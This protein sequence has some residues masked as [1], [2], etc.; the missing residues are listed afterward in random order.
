MC[1]LVDLLVQKRNNRSYKPA[2]FPLV[3]FLHKKKKELSA[4]EELSGSA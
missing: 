2:L 1:T 4:V 3:E